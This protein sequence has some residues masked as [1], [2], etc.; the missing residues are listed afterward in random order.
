MSVVTKSP[1]GKVREELSIEGDANYC[2]GSIIFAASR[3]N[4]R[5]KRSR[6]TRGSRMERREDGGLGMKDRKEGKTTSN[7]KL[8]F[9]AVGRG[10]LGLQ[11]RMRWGPGI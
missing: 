6:R 8:A 2:A 3:G 11:K 5:D 10:K 9:E 1:G 4:R 7:K